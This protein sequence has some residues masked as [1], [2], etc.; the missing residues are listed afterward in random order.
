MSMNINAPDD[1]KIVY[2]NPNN[3]MPRD[4][5]KAK[6]YLTLDKEYTVDYTLPGEFSS[7]V[8]LREVDG[9]WFNTVMFN[10]VEKA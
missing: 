4:Q 5:E 2:C 1:T 9:V 10:E 8:C 3:G 6:K 7:K